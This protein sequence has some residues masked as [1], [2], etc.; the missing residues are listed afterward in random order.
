MNVFVYETP[1]E[2]AE[3]AAR[4]FAARAEEALPALA[5]ML[6]DQRPNAPR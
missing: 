5:R 3:A 6:M 1:Q 2:L 4:D